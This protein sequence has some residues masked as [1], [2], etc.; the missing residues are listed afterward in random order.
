MP[1]VDILIK[2]I[3]L[4]DCSFNIVIRLFYCYLPMQAVYSLKVLNQG[5]SLCHASRSC[6]NFQATWCR[7]FAK[8]LILISITLSTRMRCVHERIGLELVDQLVLQ[9]IG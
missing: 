4:V 2:Q 1:I 7:N 6:S 3:F 9:C 5:F 8:L